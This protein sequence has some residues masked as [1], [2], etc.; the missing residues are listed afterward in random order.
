MMFD[1][2]NL[3]AIHKLRKASVGVGNE[4]NV[5]RGK[6]VSGHVLHHTNFVQFFVETFARDKT[7]L[8]EI[9]SN[10]ILN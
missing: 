6:G 7:F 9:P 1:C 5:T 4:R 2:R 8:S 3:G 10:F